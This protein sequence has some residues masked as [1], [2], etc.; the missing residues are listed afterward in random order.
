MAPTTPERLATLEAEL[1][2]QAARQEEAKEELA[3]MRRETRAELAAMR[4]ET[5]KE[6]KSQSADIGLIKDILTQARGGWRA[7]VAAG[8][9]IGV[10]LSGASW[11]LG[12]IMPFIWSLPK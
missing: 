7:I 6:L 9:I 2:H 8:A 3:A 5:R 1:R 10:L 12:K 4:E 11:L